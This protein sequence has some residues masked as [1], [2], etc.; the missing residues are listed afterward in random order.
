M[1]NET[2]G[3]AGQQ[4]GQPVVETTQIQTDPDG[5]KSYTPVVSTTKPKVATQPLEFGPGLTDPRSG[6]PASQP[7]TSSGPPAESSG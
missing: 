2:S 6:A 1:A 7:D 3:Q 5:Q 4:A